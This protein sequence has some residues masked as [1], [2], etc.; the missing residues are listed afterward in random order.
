MPGNPNPVPNSTWTPGVFGNPNGRPRG[1]R[2]I[3]TTEIVNQIIKSG[4]K[5]PLVT[6]SELQSNS[7]DE[8]IRATAANMLA[9]FLHSKLTA[10]PA[11]RFIETELTLPPLTDLASAIDSIA[12]IQAAVAG[13]QLDVASAQELIGMIEA[14]VRTKNIMEIST[15]QQRL[16]AIEQSIANAPANSQLPHVTGGLPSLPGTNITMPALNDEPVQMNSVPNAPHHPDWV[17]HRSPSTTSLIHNPMSPMHH[18]ILRA[19]CR[20]TEPNPEPICPPVGAY[21]SGTP[22]KAYQRPPP[23]LLIGILNGVP[24]RPVCGY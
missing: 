21:H 14:F 17:N 8:A 6:L 9:P 10:T 18:P 5:D 15:L 12:L 22:A 20:I 3:R 13:N 4:N 24:R 11:P 2:N 16:D 7:A 23:G 1:S 19:R